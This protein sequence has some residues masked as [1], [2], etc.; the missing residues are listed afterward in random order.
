[1]ELSVSPA[2]PVGAADRVVLVRQTLRAVSRGHGYRVSLSPAVSPGGVGSGAHLHFSLW[3]GEDNLFA[4][5][6]GIPGSGLRPEGEAF[7]AGVLAALPALLA[8]GA[9]S[10]ASYLRL[11]PQRWAAPWQCWGRENREAA[12]RLIAGSASTGGAAANAEIK[13]FDASA[14]PYLVVGAVIAAGLDGL[15]RGLKL[16]PPVG[17]DPASLDES[18][19]AAAGLRRL[20]TNL[21]AALDAFSALPVVR[22]AMGAPLA[23]TWLAVRR[24][25]V[26]RFAGATDEEVARASRWVW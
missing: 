6:S 3:A 2:D 14:N 13:V 18:S 23:D 21:G 19:A 9:P 10:V 22:E 16:P 15:A 8:V 12:L 25:E 20:P 17:V 11:Q 24:A 4:P 1:M 7:L 26:E 5:G